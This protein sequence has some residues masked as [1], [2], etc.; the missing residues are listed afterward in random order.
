MFSASPI[1]NYWNKLGLTTLDFWVWSLV[2]AA[3][4]ISLDV[5]VLSLP[6]PVIKN[7]QISTKR[8]ISLLGMFWLGLL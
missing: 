7:L 2:Q 6:I 8:K 5:V 3:L 1:S 4:D